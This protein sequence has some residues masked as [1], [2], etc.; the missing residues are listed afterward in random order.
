[1]LTINAKDVTARLNPLTELKEANQL[2]VETNVLHAAAIFAL[3]KEHTFS[4][5]RPTMS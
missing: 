1:M 5:T 4:N 3:F 2:F